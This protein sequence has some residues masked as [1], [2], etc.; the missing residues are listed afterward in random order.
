MA[1]LAERAIVRGEGFVSDLTFIEAYVPRQGFVVDL[2][3]GRGLFANLLRE[4]SARRR[5]L[6]VDRDA[7][8]VALA[9]AT[10]REGLR[11]SVADIVTQ[12]PPRCDAITLVDVLQVLVPAEQERLLRACAAALPEGGRLIVKA[13]EARSDPRFAF[14]YAQRL[15]AA[16]L[17]LAGHARG[18]FHFP[19]RADILALLRDCGFAAGAISMP[20]RPYTDAVFIGRRLPKPRRRAARAAS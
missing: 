9:R 2:G 18:R 1:P 15:L 19:D 16:R 4:S 14:G 11:F 3:C 17:G 7:R 13:Q 20:R 10:E 8:K 12:P 5:V 6:G